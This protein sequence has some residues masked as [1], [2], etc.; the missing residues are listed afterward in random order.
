MKI[1][2]RFFPALIFA[3]SLPLS[4][5]AGKVFGFAEFQSILRDAHSEKQI[6]VG[7]EAPLYKEARFFNFSIVSGGWSQD[8][9]GLA[10]SNKWID[11]QAGFGMETSGG[12]TT[13]RFGTTCFLAKGA[14][15][16]FLA[17]EYGPLTGSWY[18]AVLS[19][20]LA[21]WVGVGL[22]AQ[23]NI[24]VGPRAQVQFGNITLWGACLWKDRKPISTIA[25]NYGF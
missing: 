19:H 20:N 21:E 24:G 2:S 5:Q 16:A 1:V 17:F 25:L 13:G 8:Y 6:N 3:I 11:V 10:Y 9:G 15:S 7:V 14:N 18:K 22:L 23:K 12:V 4:A